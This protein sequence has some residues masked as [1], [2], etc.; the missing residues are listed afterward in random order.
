M[1]TDS[2]KTAKPTESGT[3]ETL[4]ADARSDGAGVVIDLTCGHASYQI[5]LP[6]SGSDYIQKFIADNRRPYELEMLRD[7]GDRLSQGDLVLDIGANIGNHSLYLAAVVGCN[8]IAYEPNRHLAEALSKSAQLNRLTKKLSVHPL[9]VGAKPTRAHFVAEVTSNLGSQQLAL[10][11]G[12]IKVVT[13]DAQGL[14]K[15][16]ANAIKI[17]VE[18]MELDVL[19]G[20]V[21]LIERDQPI[22][23]VECATEAEFRQLIRFMR[24]QN[25]HY[26]DTFNAT[27]THLFLPDGLAHMEDRGEQLRVREALEAYRN[28]DELLKLRANLSELNTKYAVASH[29]VAEQRKSLQLS[30]RIAEMANGERDRAEEE[31]RAVRAELAQALE[32]AAIHEEAKKAANTK[33]V[34]ARAAEQDKLRQENAQLF[35]QRKQLTETLEQVHQE[36]D[37]LLALAKKQISNLEGELVRLRSALTMVERRLHAEEG[38]NTK[39]HTRLVAL[40]GSRTYRA[41]EALRDGVKSP[42][43]LLAMPA[44]LT[45]VFRERAE[46]S[47]AF[48]FPSQPT[49][50]PTISQPPLDALAAHSERVLPTA[51][52]KVSAASTPLFRDNYKPPQRL[53]EP[54]GAPKV[55]DLLLSSHRSLRIAVIMDGFTL[56]CYM[57]EAEILELTA[58]NWK[59]EIGDFRPDFLFV[60]S[61]WRGKNE[62]W[63]RKIGH[64]SQ[65]LHNLVAWCCEN[66]V[67]T[68]FWNKEDPVHYATFLSTAKLFDA[69]FT[70]DIDCISLYKRA[71]DHDRVWLLPFACQPRIHNP[72]ETFERKDAINFAG[73]YYTRYPD[74]TRDLENFTASLPMLKP[75][76]IFDRNYGKGDPNYTFPDS[77]QPFIVGTLPPERIDMAY[78]GYRYAINL[79]S[80]KQSQSMFARRIYELLASNTITI[81]N[82][83]RGLRMMFGDLVISSDDCGEVARRFRALGESET[84]ADRLRLAALRKIMSEHTA[85]D[86][87][88]YIVSKILPSR[89][90]DRKLPE[91][92]ILCRAA[93]DIQA[94]RLLTQFAGQTL[95]GIRMVMQVTK[96]FNRSSDEAVGKNITLI[97]PGIEWKLDHLAL[98][99]GSWIACWDARDHYGPNYLYDLAMAT[100]YCNADVIGKAAHYRGELVLVDTDMVYSPISNLARR[101]AIIRANEI[102]WQSL[103]ELLDEIGGGIWQGK[104]LAVDPFN[105]CAD[106]EDFTTVAKRVDDLPDIDT[107]LSLA[108]ILELAEAIRPTAIPKDVVA[109]FNAPKLSELF[110]DVNGKNI[111]IMAVG[112]RLEVVSDLSDGQHQYV[113]SKV[114][115]RVHNL[116]KNGQLKCYFDTTPGLTLSLVVLWLDANGQRIGSAILDQLRNMTVEVPEGAVRARLGLRALGRGA[117]DI[118]G[119]DLTHRKIWREILERSRVLVLS[120]EYPSYTDLY[121]YGFLHSRLRRYAANGLRPSVLRLRGNQAISFQE[122]ENIDIITADAGT[123]D[124]ML[125]GGR[126][127]MVAVHFLS[128]AMW[129]VLKRHI[130]RVQV[131]VWAHGFDIQPWTRRRFNY[132][133]D[134]AVAD[135]KRESNARMT[136]WRGILRDRHPNLKLVFVSRQFAETVMEDLGFRIEPEGFQ[137]IHNPIDSEVFQY[138]PKAAEQRKDILMIRPFATRVYA[139]DQAVQA[140]R[141]L[142]ERP[143]FTELKF[144]IFGDGPLFD[145]TVAPLLGLPNVE[146]SRRF[147]THAEIAEK[148][149]QSGIFLVPSRLDTHGVSRDEAMSSGLVPVTSA[150]GA[151]PEFVDE[152]CGILTP[153]EDA[154]AVAD[155]IERLYYD[156]DLFL[157]LSAGA[158]KRVREQS[159]AALMIRHELA[160][161]NPHSGK[162]AGDDG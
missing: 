105:Y 79:N 50:A 64:R 11:D 77:F 126:Y 121:R 160:L 96:D 27:A 155:A 16:R 53:T 4:A 32:R 75:L 58:G 107:G 123:L 101:R 69:V 159:D 43:G 141:L 8:V 122:F 91:I 127:D 153:Y 82:Y 73:A 30:S 29:Q 158:A 88:N 2:S 62:S 78:K 92:T 21:R 114:D 147:L 65:E 116:V 52:A 143:F 24:K 120:N 19:Q 100:R 6:D 37:H 142:S 83:S 85:A 63:D 56:A 35:E 110:R 15:K 148:H 67:P 104:A 137:V 12:D 89:A 144:R 80:V 70:T 60:E 136:F 124:M 61:A 14:V 25:Y 112:D 138:F 41:G 108:R 42:R 106:V 3:A 133:T 103:A 132:I 66:K 130:D 134:Q 99:E 18:G 131:V 113:Y 72:I 26:W 109:G 135:A 55:E 36:K 140:I 118:L 71:L 38:K 7:M 95:D 129:D 33:E 5:V 102:G 128:P 149:R 45:R 48:I 111:K 23:Y 139:N 117:C 119:A 162:P 151:I 28:H 150:V 1:T 54:E 115:L 161:L 146:L 47:P 59:Q 9:G 10:G 157:R 68:A 98:S 97:T 17:D 76:D 49:P 31:T 22:L 44:R 152:S 20:A 93:D 156:P 39:L 84:G 125:A 34:A 13:L 40:I 94:R 46:P 86:R 81:S 87:L 74:R 145:E 90:P 154:Q 57:P 51:I